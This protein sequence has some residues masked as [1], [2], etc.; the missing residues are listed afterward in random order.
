MVHRFGV[1]L[2]VAGATACASSGSSPGSSIAMPSERIV[3]VDNQ[4]VLRTTVAP[5]EKVTI[6][7]APSRAFAALRAVYEELGV[8]LGVAD[9]ATG[10]VGNNDFWKTRKLGNESLSTYLNCG[11]SFS[12]P[13]ADNYR[14]YI[15]LISVVRPDGAGASQLETA[16]SANAQNM[17]GT[18][19]T[20]IACGTSGRLEDRIKK[21]VLLKVGADGREK[22]S[23]TKGTAQR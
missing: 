6:P 21:S 17:E 22:G 18:A 16:F 3:A 13:A 8:P 9:A 2:V 12:G 10:R 14:V 20:R 19:G 4:G 11:D 5:N 15:S 7:V 23:G 1:L